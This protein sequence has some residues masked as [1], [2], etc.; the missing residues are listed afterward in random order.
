MSYAAIY[1]QRNELLAQR[2]ALV[3]CANWLEAALSTYRTG[4]S[5]ALINTTRDDM[6][7]AI[8]TVTKGK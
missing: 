5:W 6:R 1:A 3:K 7:A 8:A 2:D 4:E